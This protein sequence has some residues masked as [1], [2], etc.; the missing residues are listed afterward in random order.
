MLKLQKFNSALLPLLL[1]IST[2]VM[3][4]NI[5]GQSIPTNVSA[6]DG[7]FFDKITVI[8]TNISNSRYFMVF[9]STSNNSATATPLSNTWFSQ[10]S[11]DDKTALKN[12][13]YYYWVKSSNDIY[14]R[15]SQSSFSDSNDGYI[16][17]IEV[18]DGLYLD[19]IKITWRG[20]PNK[21]FKLYRS[22]TNN[23]A[24]ATEISNWVNSSSY[25]DISAQ[26]GFSYYYWLKAASTSDGKNAVPLIISDFGYRVPVA[27]YLTV[28][29]DF[30]KI[31]VR[32]SGTTDNYFT[33]YRNTVNN[34]TTAQPLGISWQKTLMLTDLTAQFGITY[35]YWVC[36]SVYSDGRNRSLFSDYKAGFKGGYPAWNI[37]AS[38]GLYPDY[39]RLDWNGTMP[40][41]YFKV[42]RGTSPDSSLSKEISPWLSQI[43]YED[44][45]AE[46]GTNYYYW[47]RSAN[48]AYGANPSIFREK[49]IGFRGVAPI[50]TVKCSQGT[51]T[52]RI[53][54]TWTPLSTNPGIYYQV[55]HSFYSN[56]STAKPISGW[57]TAKTFDDLTYRQW[58]NNYYWVKSCMNAQ[59]INASEFGSYGTGY[60]KY[61]N[62]INAN[63]NTTTLF[64][65]PVK[66]NVTLKF[67]V[68]DPTL[69]S[70]QIADITGKIIF[71]Y[72]GQYSGNSNF[73]KIDVS[74]WNNGIYI[75]RLNKDNELTA[76]ILN[77]Q[78]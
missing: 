48:N 63:L 25:D 64:P 20:E 17:Y 72:S 36:S 8:W 23:V 4:N 11:F 37:Q 76:H 77:I 30:D 66:D 49:I 26:M 7:S 40:S 54:I 33:V 60:R 14:G 46:P 16:T 45:T 62:S 53:R 31:I 28:S 71:T 9:R 1:A 29:G 3:P 59:G 6:T 67:D 35:Y 65:N 68:Q 42:Y 57:I 21:F 22:L 24:T 38:K 52:D 73:F 27:P 13:T 18:S 75:L 5:K 32:W 12:V 70:I 69:V 2:L 74:N 44:K 56:T 15:Y 19:K 34:L 55:Y 39:T 61:P 78:N 50:N 41:A 10:T 43:Y 47:V 58:N 51:L